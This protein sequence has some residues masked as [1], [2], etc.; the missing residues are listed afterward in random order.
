MPWV[1]AGRK[2]R[3]PRTTK[4]PVWP[5]PT[6]K[7]GDARA[8]RIWRTGF[9]PSASCRNAGRPAASRQRARLKPAD[10][11]ARQA[12][13]P[14]D[15]VVHCGRK[16]KYFVAAPQSC[17]SVIGIGGLRTLLRNRLRN[18]RAEAAEGIGSVPG[19]FEIGATLTAVG[20]GPPGGRN[21]WEVSTTREASNPFRTWRAEVAVQHP[22]IWRL[23]D[24]QRCRRPPPEGRYLSK[25]EWPGV[26]C[27]M[28]DTQS[29]LGYLS[30]REDP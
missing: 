20:N 6:G 9:A 11:S 17:E 4:L 10:Q 22:V 7:R 13:A 3:P 30:V 16:L 2:L 29:Q 23:G 28:A 21:L 26:P 12:P 27:Q 8:D 14:S 15:V 1:L 5:I 19:D 25:P 18:W 24:S